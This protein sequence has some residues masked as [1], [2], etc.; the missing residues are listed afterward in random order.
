MAA[1]RFLNGLALFMIVAPLVAGRARCEPSAVAEGYRGIWYSNQPTGDEFKFKY[2][3]GLGTYPQQHA[4]IAVYSQAANK[5]FFCYGGSTGKPKELACMV[6]YFDHA[7]GKVPRPRIVL[8]KPTDDAH[9]NPTLQIDEAGHLWIFCNTHGPAENSYIF[10]SGLPY[11][12]DE[13]EQVARTS[14]SYSQPWVVP[15]RGFLFLHTRYTNGR[16]LL[17]W[18]TSGDRKAPSPY[19]LP[20]GEG[21][22]EWSSPAPLATVAQGHY[23]V[24]NQRG[25]RVATAFNYHPAKGGL[26][27]RTNLYYL[28]T[29]DFGATWRSAA[30]E[31]MATPITEV[32][33]AALV[34]N[35]EAEGQLVYLK[36]I[37]FDAA[38]RPVILYLT[39]KGYAP[40]PKAGER[41]WWTAR[42]TGH[43]WR[44]RPFTT[45][46]HNYDY[47]PLY[48]EDGEWRVIAPT[49][50]GPQPWSTGGEMVL[51]RSTN[52]GQ[53]WTRV[54]QLTSGSAR[55]HTYA[56]RP[57][58]AH[59]D[60]YVLWA[61]GNA[62]ERSESLLYFADRQGTRVW[63]LP[64]KMA[65][66]VAQP[67]TVR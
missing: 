59:P 17:H 56:R 40:G 55:N 45:S 6:S 30:G 2:S 36:D 29:D 24:S 10:R 50:P 32:K 13:F 41:A 22:D 52:N 35:Y 5:T 25:Q 9:E 19:P 7:T 34:H 18:M 43:D 21:F 64:S 47:G 48:V 62:L 37:N 16:R 28:Q 54:R 66:E 14:F 39:S 63:R 58:N 44:I 51:W 53:S 49:E 31:V 27:A 57:L 42:W 3:G 26:N 61:D 46:D 4:P 65:G 67:E 12:I 33:N 20:R 60:F 8:T 23:Q 38:G 1:R 11:S 15:G